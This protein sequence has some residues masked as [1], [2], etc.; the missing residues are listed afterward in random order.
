MIWGIKKVVFTDPDTFYYS[1]FTF[2]FEELN[3]SDVLLTP[4]W[5]GLNPNLDTANFELQFVGGLFNAGFIGVNAN[6]IETMNWWAENC[7]YRCE[8][9]FSIGHYV[10]QTYLN[11]MPVYFENVKILRHQGCNVANWNQ[12]VCQRDLVAGQVRINNYWEIVFVHFTNSTIV[13]ILSGE[14]HLLLPHLNS[15]MAALSQHG[16]DLDP[17]DFTAPKSEPTSRLTKLFKAVLGRY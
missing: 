16:L 9:N 14:D 6:S 5:R 12:I 10:D 1:D 17:A 8:K 13:G 15:Y 3:E 2:L 11:L 7:L 4:H